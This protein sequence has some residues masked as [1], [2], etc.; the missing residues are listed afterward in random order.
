MA[1]TKEELQQ[2]KK[3]YE[4]L[5]SKLEQLD[6]DELKLVTGGEVTSA[7]I[8]GYNSDPHDHNVML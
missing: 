4:D 8:V 3:E 7:N 5:C 1:K 2:L 6:D